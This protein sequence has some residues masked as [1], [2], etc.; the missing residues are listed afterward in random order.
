MRARRS[1][2]Q[3]PTTPRSVGRPRPGRAVGFPWPLSTTGRTQVAVG[4]QDTGATLNLASLLRCQQGPPFGCIC[5]SGQV[6]ARDEVTPLDS[7]CCTR[8]RVQHA[9]VRLPHSCGEDMPFPHH[10]W[11][12]RLHPQ[13]QTHPTILTGSLSPSRSLLCLLHATCRPNVQGKVQ[14]WFLERIRSRGVRLSLGATQSM[15]SSLR[16]QRVD[17][18]L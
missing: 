5:P 8:L 12:D 17:C 1:R 4:V 11:C 18:L 15:P 13:V 16:L 14:L 3:R 2:H 10:L 7:A 9:K 6:A